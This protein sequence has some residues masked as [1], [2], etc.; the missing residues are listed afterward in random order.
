MSKTVCQLE[1]RAVVEP[2]QKVAADTP[3]K[4]IEQYEYGNP[5]KFYRNRIFISYDFC[6]VCNIGKYK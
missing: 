6:C 1:Y 4:E 5:D 3:Y 2:G